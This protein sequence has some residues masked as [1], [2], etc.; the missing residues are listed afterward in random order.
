MLPRCYHRSPLARLH[1]WPLLAV[2]ACRKA[3][4]GLVPLGHAAQEG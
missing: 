4:C 2:V 1:W 3:W